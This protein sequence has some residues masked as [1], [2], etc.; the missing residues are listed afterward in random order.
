MH[1]HPHEPSRLPHIKA[2]RAADELARL[3]DER[4]VSVRNGDGERVGDGADAL[5]AWDSFKALIEI[6]AIDPVTVAG[7]VCNV[8]PAQD[9][10]LLLYETSEK[11]DVF[12]LVF[13]RQFSFTDPD[14]DYAGMNQMQ[15]QFEFVPSDQTR[16]LAYEQTWGETGDAAAW[17]TKV[18]RSAPFR[19]ASAAAP[20]RFAF[21][22]SDV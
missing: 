21:W 19:V 4:G 14:G 5:V 13:T 1:R 6:P 10:D 22:Q 17:V 8:D 15:L 9:G 11:P 18:E 12:R 3:L 20:D 16:A 2:Y 7:I